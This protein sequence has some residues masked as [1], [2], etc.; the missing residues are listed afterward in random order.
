MRKSSFPPIADE[1]TRLLVLGSL[2]G[3]KSLEARQYY[4]NPTN[5]FWRLMEVVIEAGL[6]SLEYDRR[7]ARLLS[8]GV[9]LWDV[10]AD[11]ERAGSLDSRIRNHRPN[12]FVKLA[13]SLPA[14]RGLA[15]NGGTTSRL[16]RKLVGPSSCFALFDLPSSSAA[17]CSISFA[18]KAQRWKSLREF[19]A[20]PCDGVTAM[21]DSTVS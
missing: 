16:G 9:G 8:A 19:L 14:V 5:Q 11:A 12:Q 2:P 10:I 7:L 3:E 1:R 21:P 20:A 13:S 18:Q 4:A 6:V 17:Y 15:F